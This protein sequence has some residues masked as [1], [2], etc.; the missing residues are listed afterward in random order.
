M[1][2]EDLLDYV[3]DV[4]A[5]LAELCEAE[6]PEMAAMLER[7]SSE[8]AARMPRCQLAPAQ[9]VRRVA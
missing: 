3:T 4:T 2:Q 7:V 8:A 1:T 9:I 5:Q 6:L